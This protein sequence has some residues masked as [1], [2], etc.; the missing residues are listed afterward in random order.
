MQA[1]DPFGAVAERRVSTRD[2]ATLAGLARAVA[3]RARHGLDL[4]IDN[5]LPVALAVT[6]VVRPDQLA[7]L[8]YLS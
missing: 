6:G 3:E 5:T 4:S 7:R 2:G 1:D 8:E